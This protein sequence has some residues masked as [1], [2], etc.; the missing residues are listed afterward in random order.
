MK[1]I[2]VPV[3][4]SESSCRAARFAAQLARDT[5]AKLTLMYVLDVPA[6]TALEL[7]A[8]TEQYMDPSK[9]IAAKRS[10]EKAEAAMGE[11]QEVDHVVA[12]G[13]PP[14]EILAF[15]SENRFDQIV[16]GSRGLT[17]LRELLLGS[18]S[19]RT[20]SQ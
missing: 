16:M 11:V 2:L 4:G 14:Q 8:L 13:V 15:A 3:D 12:V 17:P 7:S 20:Q 18:V 9:N 1:R 5:E 19:I 6:V 10:F